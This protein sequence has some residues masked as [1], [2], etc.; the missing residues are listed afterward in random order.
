MKKNK[1]TI[2]KDSISNTNILNNSEIVTFNDV[3]SWLKPEILVKR[4]FSYDEVKL[5]TYNNNI[6]LKRFLTALLLRILP[7]CLFFCHLIKSL[8]LKII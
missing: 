6:I 8:P 1:L 5:L 7:L 2:I 3:K 4:L